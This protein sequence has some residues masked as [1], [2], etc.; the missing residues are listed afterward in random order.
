[1]G[2]DYLYAIL[3]GIIQGLTE[4]LP[5]SSTGHLAIT[6]N[7]L[8]LDQETFGLQFDAAIQLGTTVAVIWFFKKDL[9]DL[10]RNWRKPKERKLLAALVLATL[11][12]L[13]IGVMVEKYVEGPWRSLWVIAA[14]L[15]IGGIV[16]LVVE[17]VAK[18]RKSVAETTWLDALIIGFAQSLALVPGVSRSGSTIVAG[19]LLGLKRAEAARF[20]FLLSIPII[21]LAGGKKLTEIATSQTSGNRIDVTIVGLLTAMVVGYFT[22][23]YLLKFLAH[24]KLDV[25]AYYRFA[26]AAVIIM[27]LLGR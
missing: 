5:I 14:M 27:I 20:T 26:L 9:W 17:R 18:P 15:I 21:T 7:L 25:F 19:M 10:I 1:M 3:L 2:I 6:E 12:A 22:I 11:P 8:G 13:A 24:H 4:F 16:F 23:K